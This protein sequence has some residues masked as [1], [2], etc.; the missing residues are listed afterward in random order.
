MQQLIVRCF[1]YNQ[2][3]LHCKFCI[4]KEN[5][6]IYPN[7]QLIQNIGK[8]FFKQ[9]E[10]QIRN[11]KIK[12]IKFIFQGGQILD[13]NLQQIHNSFYIL[14]DKINKLFKYQTI[15]KY[16][17]SNGMFVNYNNVKNLLQ[18]INA[19]VILNYQ[20]IDRYINKYQKQTFFNTTD[21]L[22]NNNLLYKFKSLLTNNTIKYYLNG[23]TQLFQLNKKYNKDIIFS[24][25]IANQKTKQFK[26]T[27]KLLK[28]F[29]IYALNNNYQNISSTIKNLK[30]N[31]LYNKENLLKYN[32]QKNT[33]QQIYT[34][35]II[36]NAQ[37][38]LKCNS[39][40]FNNN[41]SKF[42]FNLISSPLY[43][44]KKCPLKQAFEND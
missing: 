15:E 23:N 37:Q 12:K 3:N 44:T 10:N 39:C 28:E 17:I 14:N 7:I 13:D 38:K 34:Q 41:C 8:Y 1:L 30:T 11:Y 9:F 5:G 26:L 16:I 22:N 18:N 27:E 4:Q 24:Y 20:P 42:D 33:F 21:F 40:K 35:E 32:L 6:I 19:K 36:N 2:C 43:I 31:N 29:F 25:Y